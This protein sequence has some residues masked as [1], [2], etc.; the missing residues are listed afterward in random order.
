METV[1]IDTDVIID[2]ARGKDETLAK[3]IL[4]QKDKKLRLVVPSIVVFEFYSGSSMQE[5]DLLEKADLLFSQFEVQEINE[6]IAKI[7]AK[8][9]RERNLYQKIEAADLLIGAACLYLEAPLLTQNQ[10]HFKLIPNLEFI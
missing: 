8:I 1:V 4:G 3:L 5:P 9:N 10:K 6:E 7:A 2:F